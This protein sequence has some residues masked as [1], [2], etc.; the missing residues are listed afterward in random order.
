VRQRQPQ[1]SSAETASAGSAMNTASPHETDFLHPA[2]PIDV[3]IVRRR[4]GA[5]ARGPFGFFLGDYEGLT[6]IG[7]SFVSVFGV[8]NGNA[9]NRTDVFARL[10][11][12]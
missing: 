6:S 1:S 11:S 9:A 10:A 5:G 12:P 8:N 2:G 7:N 4:A 3:D